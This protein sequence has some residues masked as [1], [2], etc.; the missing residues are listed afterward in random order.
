MTGPL[1]TVK[2]ALDAYVTKDRAAIERVIG[3]PYR[4]AYFA[5]CW[6]N[7]QAT[8]GM[9]FIKG[10]ETGEYAFIVYEGRTAEKRFRNAELHQVV[11]G[12]IVETQVYFGWDLPH[13]AERGG[14]FKS[15]QG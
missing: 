10:T 5:R 14:F 9:D 6:P 15:N 3:D 2:A 13:P 12:R 11:D 4:E 1:V 7:S 8:T